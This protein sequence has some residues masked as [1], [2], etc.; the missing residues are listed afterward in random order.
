MGKRRKTSKEAEVL[1]GPSSNIPAAQPFDIQAL[2][3]VVAGLRETIGV[4]YRII[5]SNNN[6]NH[7]S[8]IQAILATLAT[9]NKTI[10][11]LVR[12]NETGN[13]I[14]ASNSKVIQELTK[15]NAEQAVK[16]S[17]L[18]AL[19]AS[20]VEK[21]K[22]N[23]S[24]NSNDSSNSGIPPSASNPAKSTGNL[25]PKKVKKDNSLRKRSQEKPGRLPGHV[26]TGMKLKPVS[27]RHVDLFPEEC[28][29]CQ[30]LASC[31]QHGRVCDKRYG[32]DIE[33]IEVQTEYKSWEFICPKKANQ[34]VQ[35][36]FPHFITG[37]KQYGPNIK[38]F[39]VL[40]K[41]VGFVSYYRMSKLCSALGL[42][43]S[44]G[45]LFDICNRF[46]EKCM[47]VRST[48]TS[49]LQSAP[50]LGVDET[51]A[52]INGSKAWH[53][54]TVSE[55]AT[56]I[57]CHSVRG[58]EGTLAS[59]VMQD[60]TGVVVH[61]FW[62]AYFKLKN[63]THAM[64]AAH[65]EREN[66]KA[67]ADNPKFKWPALMNDLFH[68]LQ[69]LRKE[70]LS[71]GLCGIAEDVL[72]PYLDRYDDILKE[73][74]AEDPFPLVGTKLK[75]NGQPR[76]PAYSNAQNLLKRY[77]NYKEEIL[78]F[79]VDFNVPVSNNRSEHGFR[80]LK[81][82][83][84]VFGCFRTAKGA[85]GFSMMQSVLD[86]GRKQGKSPKEIV[87][88]VFNGNYLDIFNDESLA[89]L[90]AKGAVPTLG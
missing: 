25:T 37:S 34:T 78:R 6:A 66:N 11:D 18:T 87:S 54:D 19:V 16:I 77:L 47:E 67:Q 69:R 65:L 82:A 62:S 61:D 20:L 51:G 74:L 89:I 39:A 57:T 23:K 42:D 24:A 5:E 50:A 28:S 52:N 15:L 84:N 70:L 21:D 56:L 36:P 75:K 60:Y 2:F 3:A 30:N 44:T 80:M 58:L 9:N 43:L 68:D 35:G 73:G 29:G 48:I 90:M 1:K 46:S 22:R 4:L 79:T 45:T 83:Y 27:D 63:V 40:L 38:N 76:K 71:Q 32:M 33:I 72:L 8:E 7:P 85:E 88:S 81:V 49:L 53:H 86:T 41:N 59:G 64:C 10:E 12:A 13:K 17:E 55:D 26:G 14:N 31:M